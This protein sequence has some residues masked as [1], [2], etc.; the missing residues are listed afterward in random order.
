MSRT[1]SR[2][3]PW[4]ASAAAL[5]TALALHPLPGIAQTSEVVLRPAGSAATATDTTAPMDNDVPNDRWFPNGTTFAP[6]IVA[7]REVALRGSLVMANRGGENDYGDRH[8]EAEAG[9]GYRT[10]VVRLREGSAD[11]LTLDLGFEVGIF[12]RFH[13]GKL[14]RTLIHADYRVGAPFSFSYKEWGGR[15]TILHV[16]SHQG[17]DYLRHFELTATRT[18]QDGF[19]LILARRVGASVRLYGGG[20]AHYHVSGGVPNR[21]GYAGFEWDP[22]PMGN[23][24]AVWPFVAAHLGAVKDQD[25]LAAT[26]AVGMAVRLGGVVMRWEVRGHT[27]P[28]PMGQHYEKTE[29]F[30]GIGLQVTPPSW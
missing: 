15:F 20:Y 10:N 29:S 19:E 26:G 6:L 17:D 27:G 5:L 3:R 1:H 21:G 13:L 24:T 22:E 28:S 25:D 12:S 2:S 7:P 16:S 18:S 30:I 23:G 8:A 4:L 14:R 11:G 9:I